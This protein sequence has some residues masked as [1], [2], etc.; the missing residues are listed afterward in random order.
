[1]TSLDDTGGHGVAAPPL[2]VDLDGTLVL[3][4]TLQE[5][6]IVL[7]RH[8]PRRLLRGCLALLRRDRAACKA[9][10]AAGLPAAHRFAVSPTVLERLVDEA[11]SGRRLVLATAADTA[12][13]RRVSA[14][15]PIFEDVIA[16]A[17][18]ENLTGVRKRRAI[19]AWLVQRDLPP[20]YDYLGNDRVDRP[21]WA[22]A[23]RA[24][25]A[26]RPGTKPSRIAGD[27]AVAD[28]I[29]QPQ[30]RRSA[31]LFKG[32]RLRHWSKNLLVF[33]PI[34]LSQSWT[35]GVALAA[36]GAAFLAFGLVASATY[37]WNDLLDLAAD[38]AHPDKRN[39]PFASGDLRPSEGL[40]ASLLLIAA[41]VV[42]A[43]TTVG[44]VLLLLL[45]GY[46]VV[47]LAYSL[48][49]KRMAI[50]DVTTLAI[51]HGYRILV[52]GVVTGIE[53]SD[54]LIAFSFFLFG[55]LAVAKRCA[56]FLRPTTGTDTGLPGR[57][58]RSEDFPILRS[59]GIVASL[60]STV[61]MSIYI[62]A[63]ETAALYGE[64]RLLW[65]VVLVLFVW[66]ARV[67]LAIGRGN[68]QDDPIAW[69]MSDGFSLASAA[70]CVGLVVLASGA[71][72]LG[73]EGGP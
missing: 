57:G 72:F 28:V 69:A 3:G 65:P 61:V 4:D 20:V 12:I 45:A 34:L 31:A 5:N 68:L 13:A 56:E 40:A 9:I 48:A 38:R 1:M 33:L 53:V 58:Y 73:A 16:S 14:A 29:T 39:R 19:E 42:V 51:L 36:A 54:W 63:P 21:I 7:L 11:A 35:D 70:V 18:G 64:P 47:T 24:L 32:A 22:G 49:L 41:A 52:G 50:I 62:M 30:R 10:L 66:Q 17:G 6:A 60:M 59:I 55:G 25:L 37:F 8:A 26:A 2:F 23:R 71:P 43:L 67:W 15:H 27:L 44:P 46:V